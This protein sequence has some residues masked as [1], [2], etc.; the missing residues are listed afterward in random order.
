MNSRLLLIVIVLIVVQLQGICAAGDENNYSKTTRTN[1]LRFQWRPPLQFQVEETT[2]KD[3]KLSKERCTLSLVETN[4]ELLLR[5]IDIERLDSNGRS[6]ERPELKKVLAPVALVS[7]P[8]MRISLNGE[9]L[10]TV[11]WK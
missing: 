6:V 9:F 8:S 11:G 7:H 4:N 3:G 1:G 2:E 10:G 5:Y